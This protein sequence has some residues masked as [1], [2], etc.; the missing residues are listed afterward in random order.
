MSSKKIPLTRNGYDKLVKEL[1]YLKG[2][3]R[4]S[5]SKEIGEAR[6]KGDI[7]ENAEYDAAKE[8]QA[9]NE[10]KIADL[11]HKL[12]M[13]RIIE[14]KDLTSDKVSL[15]TTV[16]VKDKAS[17]EEFSYM[18]VSEEESDFEASKISASSPVGRALVGKKIGDVVDIKVPAGT[19]KYEILEITL[20]Q[21]S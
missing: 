8:A 14:E 5:I 12:S 11:E 6:E 17:G 18:L 19:L 2:E 16:R 3:K 10:K 13:A 7:S 21:K 20:G 4:R 15:G 1:D 9:L